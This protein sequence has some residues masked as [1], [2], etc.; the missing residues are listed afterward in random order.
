MVGLRQ[1]AT[2]S[3]PM[4]SEVAGEHVDEGFW[5]HLLDI[6]AGGE[7]LFAAGQQDATD[8]VVGFEIVDRRG[9]FP[10]HAERERVEHLRTV[11]A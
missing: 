4:A 2:R 7:R 1:L 10:E 5:L 11:A 8:A 3:A 9:D 6:G